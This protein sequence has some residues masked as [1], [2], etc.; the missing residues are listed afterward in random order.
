MQAVSVSEHNM[1]QIAVTVLRKGGVVVYPTETSYGLGGDWTNPRVHEKVRRI[2]QRPAE[3]QLPVIVSTHAIAAQYVEFFPLARKLAHTFWPGPLSLV[4]PLKRHTLSSKKSSGF[5]RFSPLLGG[6][7]QR[8]QVPLPKK[9]EARLLTPGGE[10]EGVGGALSLRISSHPI[11]QKLA[12]GL[13]RPIIATSA[14]ISGGENLYSAAAVVREFQR[15]KH[16]PDLIIDAGTLPRRKPST[17]IQVHLDGEMDV[18]RRGPIPISKLK[19]Q[20]SKPQLK[21]R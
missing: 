21:T 13:G 7:T 6:E 11:A 1:I 17:I 4:L 8:Q 12:R 18:L 14:N 20:I 16:R 3:K 19:A 9:G 10:G 5:F 15:R 2:K